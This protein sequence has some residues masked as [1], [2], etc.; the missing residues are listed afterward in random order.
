MIATFQLDLVFVL[1]RLPARNLLSL[2]YRRV[3]ETIGLSHSRNRTNKFGLMDTIN[4]RYLAQND[5]IPLQRQSSVLCDTQNFSS[6][7][8]ESNTQKLEKIL[9]NKNKDKPLQKNPFQKDRIIS[10]ASLH[11]D[12][13]RCDQS[14]SF[15]FTITNFTIGKN[16]LY[17][18][19]V[20]RTLYFTTFLFT[21]ASTK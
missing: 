4:F 1:S 10:L 12:F 11:E 8:P 9:E 18:D 6:S 19:I 20:M 5:C 21:L 3:G 17:M 2:C 15:A 13:W 14:P 16:S 7:L